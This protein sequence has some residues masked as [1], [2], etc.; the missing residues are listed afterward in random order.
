ML[1]IDKTSSTFVEL[2]PLFCPFQ[3][4]CI[5]NNCHSF[6][7]KRSITNFYCLNSK[8]CKRIG[9]ILN[10]C[11]FLFSVHYLY[12]TCNLHLFSR[13]TTWISP[14]ILLFSLDP[15][16]DITCNPLIFLR[17]MTWIPVS[18]AILVNSF[19]LDPPLGYQ[20]QS[21]HFLCFRFSRSTTC[22]TCPS[23]IFL[24]SALRFWEFGRS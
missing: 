7:V 19:S 21:S 3:E 8:P 12:V 18:L 1:N 9:C 15:P 24:I 14:E 23:A 20:L 11:G 17:S 16:L 2:F 4:C 5:F 6:H 22:F 13:S 10:F